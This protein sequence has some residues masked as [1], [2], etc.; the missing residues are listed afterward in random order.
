MYFKRRLAAFIID[1]LLF[2]PFYFM[3]M[4][5]TSAN[6][7][8]K[9]GGYLTAEMQTLQ[10]LLLILILIFFMS[11]DIING[12][13]IGKRIAKIKIIDNS[14]ENVAWWQ[15]ILRNITIFIWPL[16]ALLLLLDKERIGDK[17]ARTKV[18]ILDKQ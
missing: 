4:L 12:Q 8:F 3:I 7:F 6:I 17:V 15:L 10:N 16:E 18:V 11:K 14:G 13:S 5:F 2:M 1:Y 9:T